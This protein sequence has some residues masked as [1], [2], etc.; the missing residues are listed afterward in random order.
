MRRRAKQGNNGPMITCP[1]RKH[2][3]TRGKGCLAL[4]LRVNSMFTRE[5]YN[6][7]VLPYVNNAPL[8]H[9]QLKGGR[10]NTP[11]QPTQRTSPKNQDKETIQATASRR[12]LNTAHRSCYMLDI[13]WS[14]H[15]N[16]LLLYQ[17][18][19]SPERS[20]NPKSKGIV[21]PYSL[22]SQI[23]PKSNKKG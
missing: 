11:R 1:T 10:H 7:N 3:N 18:P 13:V 23:T 14:D 16:Y 4:M 19:N 8:G 21:M 15:H 2:P 5:N 22:T 6:T 9:H 20:G 17:A 12:P